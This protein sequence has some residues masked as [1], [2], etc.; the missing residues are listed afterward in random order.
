MQAVVAAGGAEAA[1]QAGVR[2]MAGQEDIR[3]YLR[4]P[5]DFARER[6]RARLGVRFGANVQPG[7]IVAIGADTLSPAGVLSRLGGICGD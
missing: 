4:N 7:Q 6:A 5:T 2:Q 3:E 1:R